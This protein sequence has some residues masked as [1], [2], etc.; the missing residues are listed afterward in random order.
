M[1]H[2]AL[3]L[4]QIAGDLLHALAHRHDNTWMAFA[5]PVVSTGGT[6][7]IAP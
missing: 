7:S 1:G 3:L 5:E 2:D 4:R 6:K